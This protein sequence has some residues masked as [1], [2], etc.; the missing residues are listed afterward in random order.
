VHTFSNAS[1][2]TRELATRVVA[3]GLHTVN[4]SLDGADEPTFKRLR[5]G[6]TLARYKRCFSNLREARAAASSALPHL[7]AMTVLSKENYRQVPRMLAIAEELGAETIIFTKLNATPKPDQLPLQLGTDEYAWLDALPAY[8]GR[9][10]MLRAWTPWTL[11]ERVACYWPSHM[12]YVTVEGDVTACC[13][14]FDSREQKFGNVFE[15]S[16]PEIWNDAP[17]RAFRMRLMNGDLPDKC[18]TC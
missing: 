16:G 8:E 1:L 18:K 9:V 2:I 3:A 7:G 5:K 17:Y 10:Q 4:F 12:A 6:G 14:Y 15:K 13:N 11:A